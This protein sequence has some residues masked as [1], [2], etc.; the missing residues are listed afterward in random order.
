MS[1]NSS[2]ASAPLPAGFEAEA[3]NIQHTVKNIRETSNT[4][5]VIFDSLKV[6]RVCTVAYKKY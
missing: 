3:L 6:L 5:Y 2:K 4:L 1:R